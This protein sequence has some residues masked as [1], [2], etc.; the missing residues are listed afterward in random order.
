ME[1]TQTDKVANQDTFPMKMA[2]MMSV[3]MVF[4]VKLTHGLENPEI[5][6]ELSVMVHSETNEVNATTLCSTNCL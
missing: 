4:M 6:P 1:Q 5:K 2:D 3:L